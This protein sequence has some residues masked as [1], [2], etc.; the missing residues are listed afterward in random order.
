MLYFR[1]KK[2]QAGWLN[3]IVQEHNCDIA[4]IRCLKPLVIVCSLVSEITTVQ[5]AF[6][7]T[8]WRKVILARWKLQSE[9]SIHSFMNKPS[10]GCR[11][12][13]EGVKAVSVAQDP[14]VEKFCLEGFVCPRGCPCPCSVLWQAM[15]SVKSGDHTW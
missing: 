10:V 12:F 3:P 6:Q 14:A 4:L 2:F 5:V 7:Y 8:L 1:N 9:I 13:L 11:W 15:H